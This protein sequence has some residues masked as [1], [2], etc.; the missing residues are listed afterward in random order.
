MASPLFVLEIISLILLLSC[1]MAST[2]AA[3][4][5]AYQKPGWLRAPYA[6]ATLLALTCLL[7]LLTEPL[8]RPQDATD[9]H[10][11][12]CSVAIAAVAIL[13]SALVMHRLGRGAVV[14]PMQAGSLAL[15]TGL[16]L[17]CLVVRLHEVND[18]MFHVLTWHYLPTALGAGLG[19]WL[20]RR[21]LRW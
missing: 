21:I 11:L 17:G 20:G 3:Y 19:V 15:R 12:S 16:A 1:V 18:S 14:H 5:D 8:S 2:L 10:G 6:L 9:I 4:P 7:Q 13:P